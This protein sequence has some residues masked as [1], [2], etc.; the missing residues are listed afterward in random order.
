MNYTFENEALQLVRTETVPNIKTEDKVKV[1]LGKKTIAFTG[2][3]N[4]DIP[5]DLAAQWTKNF[6]K[7]NPEPN[8]VKAHF[9]GKEAIVAILEQEE[10]V[11]VR[12][13]YSIDE[14]GKK[15][16]IV[17]GV[18]GDGNDLHNGLIADRSFLCPPYC[19]GGGGIVSNYV[20]AS[21][22]LFG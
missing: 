22:L 12:I 13:Y 14:N 15:H 1:P 16:L 7:A 10:C 18:K 6:R 2:L 20:E 8:T 3:E 9:F 21:P 11:G 4:H 19:T 5:L 17:V